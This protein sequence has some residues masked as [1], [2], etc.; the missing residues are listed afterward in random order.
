MLLGELNEILH[1]NC[2]ACIWHT[3][4]V[5]EIAAIIIASSS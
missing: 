3:T 1:S 2:F 5:Q 4:D